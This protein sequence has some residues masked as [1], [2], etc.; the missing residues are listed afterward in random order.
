MIKTAFEFFSVSG[1]KIQTSL[2]G[3]FGKILFF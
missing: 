3:Y 2:L 1:G